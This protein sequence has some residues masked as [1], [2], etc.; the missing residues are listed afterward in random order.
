[1]ARNP[2]VGRAEVAL[3]QIAVA[4]VEHESKFLVGKRCENAELGGL[5]EFPGGKIETGET[6]EQAAVRECREESGLAVEAVGLLE[7]TT[8]D[9]GDFAVHIR[10]IACRLLDVVAE[11]S[12]PYRWVSADE[13]SDYE[14][15]EANAAILDR[16][17]RELGGQCSC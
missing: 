17:R 7:E 14:F 2:N 3:K 8:H 13:L 1:M 9:Y 15:P 6:A 4:V 16:L 5:W 10:F 11:V 12:A